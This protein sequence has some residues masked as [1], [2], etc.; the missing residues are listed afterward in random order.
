MV[1][2]A[3]TVQQKRSAHM[4]K[5]KDVPKGAR[6][7]G[8]IVEGTC[9]WFQLRKGYGFLSAPGLEEGVFVHISNLEKDADGLFILPLN[10]GKVRFSYEP[11]NKEGKEDCF[12]VVKGTKVEVIDRYVPKPRE[13]R[14]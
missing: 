7:A 10:G 3:E 9:K 14:E 2:L 11:S 6:G 8:T 13:E 4:T 5:R 12:Q 1:F